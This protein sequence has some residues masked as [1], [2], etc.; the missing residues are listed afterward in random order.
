MTNQGSHIIYITE[1][2]MR[3]HNQIIGAC[4]SGECYFWA[5]G[6][7]LFYFIGSSKMYITQHLAH[8]NS[9]IKVTRWSIDLLSR[10]DSQVKNHLP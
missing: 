4:A 2:P 10:L 7:I 9:Y 5:I 3:H 1:K 6:F 8:T